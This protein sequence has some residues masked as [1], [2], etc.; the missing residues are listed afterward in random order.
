MTLACIIQMF[1]IYFFDILHTHFVCM[2]NYLFTNI[3]N[4]LTLVLI[5]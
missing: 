4:K 2:K 5:K 3:W 1:K